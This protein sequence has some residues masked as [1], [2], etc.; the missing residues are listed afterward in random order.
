[1]PG[2]GGRQG[3]KERCRMKKLMK[4]LGVLVVLLALVVLVVSLSLGTIIE[5]GVGT[6]G[7]KVTG[8]P[9]S[10]DNV[11]FSLMKGKAEVD[12]MVVG[13]P[14]GFHTAHAFKLGELDVE[15]DVASIFS[16]RVVIKRILIDA[17]EITYELGLKGSNIGKLQ[18]QIEEQN[19]DKPAAEPSPE[20][21]QADA[22]GKKVEIAEIVISGGR[23]NL[24]A[25][26]L[27]GSQV[28][29]PLPTITLKDIGKEKD[30]ASIVEVVDEIVGAVF[31]AATG[32]V[33]GSGKLV[34]KGLKATGDL[35][36]GGAKLG[37]DAAK[38]GAG[39]A[40][41]L[42]AGGAK[43]GTDAAKLGAGAA[44]GA[45][46]L[47]ADVVGKGAGVAGDAAG[48]LGQ[49]LLKGGDAAKGGA[50]KLLGGVKGV[51]KRPEE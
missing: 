30:G 2:S 16:D 35:A 50:K 5:K 28:P 13:N 15:V 4:V 34:G 17:P 9:V 39:A 44:T 41:D 36:V 40:T 23:I 37:A 6:V 47:G 33:K 46:K 1:L 19:A 20:T 31:Q 45:A 8:V 51:L 49:G 43:L 42:A 21:E 27:G 22:G 25:T 12:N 7:P 29:I 26:A 11:G 24:S 38:L 48:K 14:E 10:V 3:W 18:K 32:T